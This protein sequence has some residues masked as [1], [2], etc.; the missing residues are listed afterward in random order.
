MER[1]RI[2]CS[3]CRGFS[4]VSVKCDIAECKRMSPWSGGS[5]DRKKHN[6]LCKNA[7]EKVLREFDSKVVAKKY[8]RLYRDVLKC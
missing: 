6:Q 3:S 5:V 7:R 2:P 8:I 1:I 4:K